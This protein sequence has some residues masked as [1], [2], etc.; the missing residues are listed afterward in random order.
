ML[1]KLTKSAYREKWDRNI[2]FKRKYLKHVFQCL[3]KTVQNQIATRY[4]HKPVIFEAT[5]A[6]K[7]NLKQEHP[8]WLY[9]HWVA[10]IFNRGALLM[11][12]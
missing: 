7:E 11:L 8:I 9:L 6:P 4:L 10:I 12:L 2:C 1:S 5:L 3:I